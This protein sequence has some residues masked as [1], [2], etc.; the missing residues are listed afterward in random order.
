MPL[1]I[2]ATVKVVNVDAIQVQSTPKK[3][4]GGDKFHRIQAVLGRVELPNV[5]KS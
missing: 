3:P 2:A 1:R 5:L 4:L